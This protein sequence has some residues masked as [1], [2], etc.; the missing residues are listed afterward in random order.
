M[1]SDFP[2]K[3]VGLIHMCN[4][5]YT[6]FNKSEA[7]LVSIIFCAHYVLKK[8]PQYLSKDPIFLICLLI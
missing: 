7:L 2:S 3:E 6:K 1:S 4:F 5:E 8:N